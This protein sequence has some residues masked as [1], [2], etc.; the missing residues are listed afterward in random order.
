M[1]ITSKFNGR[2]R[3]CGGVIKVGESCDWTRGAGITHVGECPA[4]EAPKNVAVGVGVFRK[5]GRVYV[6]KPNQEKTRFYAKE[7]VESPARMTESGLVVDFETVY[8]PGMV[9]DLAES[10]RWNLADARDFLTKFARCI[11]CGRHLKAAKSVSGAIGPVCAKYFAT[12]HP[13]TCNHDH[14]APSG[15]PAVAEE[16]IVF[17]SDD[18]TAPMTAKTEVRTVCKNAMTIEEAVASLGSAPRYSE[19]PVDLGDAASYTERDHEL[20]SYDLDA[21][22]RDRADNEAAFGNDHESAGIY[23]DAQ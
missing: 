20:E 17:H 23:G 7:I 22:D 10:D 18:P 11:V 4:N 12:T 2:C 15:A 9:Y 8:R 3:K 1:K 6:V 21:R 14:G 19:P 5:D 13:T 16:S